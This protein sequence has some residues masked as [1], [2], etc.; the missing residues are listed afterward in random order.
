VYLVLDGAQRVIDFLKKT[1]DATGLR[2]YDMPDG[3]I[4]H[5]GV[6]IDYT[7]GMIAGGGGAW[8]PF[9]S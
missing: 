2:R 4:M 6:R 3:S 5:A 8:R 9:P 1:F 7:V